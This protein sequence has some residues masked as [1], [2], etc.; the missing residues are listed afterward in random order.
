MNDFETV[1]AHMLHDLDF[2]KTYMLF[3]SRSM[4]ARPAFEG[5]DPSFVI[6]AQITDETDY[7]FSAPYSEQNHN[8]LINSGFAYWP[9]EQLGY[10]DDLTT[11][12]YVKCYPHK[13][14]MKNPEIFSGIPTVN[15]VLRTDY[16]LFRQTWNSID[17]EFYYKYIWKRSPTYDF[18]E[19]SLT[20]T[21]I[22]DI[23]N[24][25]FR[26]AKYIT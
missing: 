24:Q 7:D 10:K 15:V 18:E 1:P 17:P 4:A 9:P 8:I 20:K 12:V 2:T 22:R 21:K 6:G 23:M 13:F 14:D 19:M 16:H 25:L 3:G 11:G 5:F 26:T